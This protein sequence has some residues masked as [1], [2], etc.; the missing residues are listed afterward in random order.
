V[1]GALRRYRAYTPLLLLLLLGA[2]A[3]FF[4]QERD[5]ERRSGP[6]LFSRD[7]RSEGTLALAMWLE[8]MGYEVSR[9][10]WTEAV[11]DENVDI[12]F[13]LRPTRRFRL[14][15]AED[16][17]DWVS[18]G[19]TLVYHPNLF[20]TSTQSPSPADG[21][22]EALGLEARRV[23]RSGNSTVGIPLA[24]RPEL[25]DVGSGATLELVLNDPA[26]VPMLLDGARVLG[27]SRSLGRG[28]VYAFTTPALFENQRIGESG[29]RD[30]VLSVLA[31]HPN[32][33]RVAFDEYHHGSVLDPDLMT[34][35]RTSPWGWAILYAAGTTLLFLIWGGRRFGPAVVPERVM[36]RSTGDY[37]S[38]LAGLIQRS[39]SVAWAQRESAR[40]SRRELSR[41]LGTRP[42]ASIAELTSALQGRRGASADLAERIRD[43]EGAP[44]SERGLIDCVRDVERELRSLRG[45]EGAR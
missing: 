16:L 39:R 8:R 38:A 26:W 43:L 1:I 21:L 25:S 4:V 44:L 23:A 36:G 6:S 2:A 24:A 3:G 41:L 42:D 33:R 32:A 34:A 45:V 30:V 15:E 37:V 12:L 14:N 22:S 29:N 7:S 19:G 31:R 28:R 13:L 11:P 17:R 5:E 20:F 27:A 40:L 18:D 35:V 10:E 9:V